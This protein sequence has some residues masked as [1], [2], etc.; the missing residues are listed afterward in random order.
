[1]EICI[2]THQKL[3][4]MLIITINSGITRF[5][6]GSVSKGIRGVLFMLN[7]S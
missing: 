6:L 7:G 1:M 5:A 3:L 2:Q 4:I